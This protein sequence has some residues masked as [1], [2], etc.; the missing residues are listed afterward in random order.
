MTCSKA[1]A[2]AAALLLVGL[3]SACGSKST[4]LSNWQEPSSRGTAYSSFVVIAVHNNRMIRE[5]YEMEMV[6]ALA[7]RGARVITGTSVL[8][9][10]DPLN[11]DAVQAILK[12][13]NIEAAV[14]T[15]LIS[16][17]TQEYFMPE[18]AATS[19]TAYYNTFWGFYSS[20]YT[21]INEPGFMGS[22]TIV[23]LESN[24]YEVAEG[25]L[26]WTGVVETLN[27]DDAMEAVRSQ[28]KTV[29]ERFEKLGLVGQQK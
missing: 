28:V 3:L 27:P 26:V 21:M 16:A 5:A 29:T 17:D 10:D 20:S 14:V 9:A 1:A 2:I 15:R 12:E 11:R 13:Q 18:S 25:T 4:L 6:E 24:L 7:A 8:P 19:A 23:N 22:E